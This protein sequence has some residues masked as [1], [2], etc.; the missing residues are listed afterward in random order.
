M[1]LE[2]RESVGGEAQVVQRR[3][4][5][6]LPTEDEVPAYRVSHLP[7]RG[8]CEGCVAGPRR[9]WPHR[10]RNQEEEL[11]TPEVRFCFIGAGAGEEHVVVHV[12]RDRQPKLSLAHVVPFK[13][14]DLDGVTAQVV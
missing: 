11:P 5:A 6:R 4:P 10:T 2:W 8:W 13:G 7:F 14:G 9:D 1:A 12:G 3:R